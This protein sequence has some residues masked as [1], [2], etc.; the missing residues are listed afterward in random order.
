MAITL[1]QK[2]KFFQEELLEIKNS[3]MEKFLIEVLKKFP[4]YFFNDCP[5]SSTGKYH[6]PGLNKPDGTLIHTKLVVRVVK[7]LTR[8]S[9]LDINRTDALI[10]AAVC[11]DM[12]KQGFEKSG[13]TAFE[14]PEL[15]VKAVRKVYW[16]NPDLI[17][18]PL[19]TLMTDS[20]KYHYGRWGYHKMSPIE[21]GFLLGLLHI[22]DAIASKL[23]TFVKGLN[24]F[25]K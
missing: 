9:D 3:G 1:A 8:I 20:M 21:T 18:F 10:V 25:K 23:H 13:H 7:E 16:D 19:F 22:A 24:I 12:F 17:P 11:H 6:P 4:D 14:H 2:K 5:A 15:A